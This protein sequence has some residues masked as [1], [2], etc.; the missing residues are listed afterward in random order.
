MLTKST[1]HVS[2]AL[3]TFHYE[4]NYIL[5]MFLMYTNVHIEKVKNNHKQ[6]PHWSL[7]HYQNI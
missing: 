3:W 2:A 5:E 4:D 1:L 6:Q 7:K